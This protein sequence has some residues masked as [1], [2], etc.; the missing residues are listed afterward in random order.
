M[1]VNSVK[2]LPVV[3]DGHLVGLVSRADLMRYFDRPDA[4][5]ADDVQRTLASP[6]SAP[7][8]HHIVS[9]VHDGEV[10]L[11]RNGPPPK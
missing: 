9:A 4:D 3:S 5:I 1:L 10:T 6:L 7:D 11:H 8:D 2:R